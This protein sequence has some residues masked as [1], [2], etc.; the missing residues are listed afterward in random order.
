MKPIILGQIGATEILIVLFLIVAIVLF[1]MRASYRKRAGSK[2]KR[3]KKMFDAKLITGEE[4]ETMKAR[5]IKESK[6]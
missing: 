2:L 5:I 4:Y 3:A 6:I 1:I